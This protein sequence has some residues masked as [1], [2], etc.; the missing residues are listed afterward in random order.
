MSTIGPEIFFGFHTHDVP[1]YV[2][3]VLQEVQKILD[4]HITVRTLV[5]NALR[6]TVVPLGTTAIS[7]EENVL[8]ELCPHI[9][10]DE[11]EKARKLFGRFFASVVSL[12]F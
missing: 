3:N 1:I 8:E 5:A 4:A 2:A 9:D 12:E 7:D 6:D 11:D 10:G